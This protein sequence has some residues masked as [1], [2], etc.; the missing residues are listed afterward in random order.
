MEGA[1][2]MCSW[3][4]QGWFP[5]SPA[6]GSDGALERLHPDRPWKT[7]LSRW[8]QTVLLSWLILHFF[9]FLPVPKILMFP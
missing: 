1:A 9:L 4:P 5:L 7:L 2:S 3:I 6:E 8:P